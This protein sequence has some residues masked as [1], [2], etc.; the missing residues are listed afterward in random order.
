MPET[1]WT[2]RWPDG[3][4]ERLYSPSSIVAEIFE[5][6]QSYPV[7][8]FLSRARDAL[9]Q[10]SDRVERKYGFACSSAMD[11]LGRIE[12]RVAT[13]DQAGQVDCLDISQ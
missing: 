10:A 8:D 11:Q 7:P 13:L 12:A 5:P 1:F 3:A 6:G 2:V 4:E 9:Q